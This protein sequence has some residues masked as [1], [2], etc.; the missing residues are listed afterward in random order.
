MSATKPAGGRNPIAKALRTPRF[1][2]QVRADRKRKA[3]AARPPKA[4]L[5]R[6]VDLRG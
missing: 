2:P 5:M 3:A 4:T 1:K 6:G